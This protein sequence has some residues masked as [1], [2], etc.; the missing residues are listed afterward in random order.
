MAFGCGI[1]I[2][3][4]SMYGAGRHMKTVD[5]E[6]IPLYFRVSSAPTSFYKRNNLI[7]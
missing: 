7:G 3:S 5:P 4:Q 2:A 1:A 6:L